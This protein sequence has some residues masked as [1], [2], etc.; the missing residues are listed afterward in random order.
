MALPLCLRKA[1]Q[2]AAPHRQMQPKLRPRQVQAT[3]P[4]VSILILL[5]VSG[6]SHGNWWWA[7]GGE[8]G[9]FSRPTPMGLLK[10][11]STYT[12]EL[13]SV[14]CKV[15]RNVLRKRVDAN[16]NVYKP[17]NLHKPVLAC[18]HYSAKPLLGVNSGSPLLCL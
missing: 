11:S 13:F 12:V 4:D 9:G 3:G 1:G 18:S 10:P 16:L 7:G 2:A 17:I 6:F 8:A 15:K 14:L 5:F